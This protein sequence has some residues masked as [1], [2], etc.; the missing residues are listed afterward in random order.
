VTNKAAE[1]G[2]HEKK[3]GGENFSNRLLPE[4]EGGF[5]ASADVSVPKTDANV[6]RKGSQFFGF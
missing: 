6:G 5:R 3:G 4:R 2:S 1:Y